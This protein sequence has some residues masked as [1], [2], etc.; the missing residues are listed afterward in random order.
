MRTGF[1]LLQPY[2][3]P[4]HAT[5][6]VAVSGGVDSMVLLTLLADTPYRVIA[7]HY[8]HA[9][10]PESAQE[11]PMVQAYAKHLGVTYTASRWAKPDPAEAAARK[12]RYAWLSQVAAAYHTPYL[13]VA[14]HGNDQLESVL[15]QLARS[16]NVMKMTGLHA[17]RQLGKLQVLRPLL[18]TDKAAL[19]AYAKAH[20]VPY[21][22]DVTN[23][24]V[25]YARNRVRHLIVPQL[26]QVN[27]QVVAHTQKFT[28]Q[29]A[30]LIALAAPRL[31]A[32][33]EAAL[34]DDTLDWHKVAQEPLAVRE[35]VLA[36]LFERWQL[37][38][39]P[40]VSQ[41]IVSA[42][43]EGA[44]NREFD[45]HR[46]RLVVSYQTLQKA[47]PLLPFAPVPLAV[48]DTWQQ[49]APNL[50]AGLF[51]QVPPAASTWAY[52]PDQPGVLRRRQAGDR[53][54]NTHQ[55]LSRWLIDHKVPQALRDAMLLLANESAVVWWDQASPELFHQ[56]QTDIIQA[57]LALKTT[58]NDS[59]DNNGK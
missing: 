32:L 53:L 59:E 7:A 26:Q 15:L 11:G 24:D 38:V 18:N 58:A 41:A 51:H 49:V 23:A 14:H 22:E 5:L 1:A 30:G 16:G 20:Q 4:L 56:P 45:V 27:P 6:I 25:H 37:T 47:A 12:A 35:L 39:A 48:D 55:K 31:T 9:L 43:D 34:V 3:L 52:V 54:G 44:G 33:L 29:L 17:Q 50:W 28:T 13:V 46:Q 2:Q 10:R 40:A 57:V 36:Q 8:D 42:L 21:A 19:Y